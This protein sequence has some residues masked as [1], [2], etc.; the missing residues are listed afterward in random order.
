MKKLIALLLAMVMVLPLVAACGS[1][2]AGSGE[3]KRMVIA[4]DEWYG[5]DAFQQDTWSTV[6]ALIADPLFAI[7]PD[8][9]ALLD[10]IATDLVVSEDGLTM[11]FTIPEGK[12]YATGEQV[13]P[14]DVK[15][16]FEYGKG[17]SPYADGYS[18][19]ES[20]DIDGRQVVFHLTNFRSDML[21]YLGECFIC[22]LDKDQ[23]DSMS[24]DELTWGA[25][26]YGPYYVK[27]YEPGSYVD[28]VPNPKYVCDN[29]LVTNKGVGLIDEIHV[30][31][32]TDDFTIIEELKNGEIDYWNA[33]TIDAQSQLAS[34]ENIKIVDKSYPV[35]DFMEINTDNSIFEDVRLRQALCLLLDREALCELTNGAA[36]PA[37]SMVYDSMMYFSQEGKDD[38]KNNY[39]N[40]IDRALALITEAGWADTD[41]DGYLD[42]DGQK[43]EFGMY[44]STDTTRQIIVQGMQEQLKQYGIQMNCEAIDWNYVHEYLQ[45][46]EY[47]TGIHSLE[48]A[49]PI[50]VLN[51][52]FDD[53]NAANNN[54]AFYA[55][56]DAAASTVDDAER[57]TKLGQIEIELSK[58]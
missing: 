42:K 3:T 34:A 49:E 15:A 53:P 47:D 2:T 28:L 45:S 40:D 26:P 23:I 50:L 38:F 29:P 4:D 57:V 51:C 22:I 6:Q 1:D 46:N 10:S 36:V 56:I 14:E 7:D 55:A 16:S 39:C 32:N 24:Q 44:A 48:W 20:I 41:G 35:V 37:Y 27:N 13:E 17:I 8:T 54:E 31:F 43:F 19:I 33:P 25:V 30:K 18:N 11:T 5:T 58:E 12:Y 52:C 9:G 21:Y